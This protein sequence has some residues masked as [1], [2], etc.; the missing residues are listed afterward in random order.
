MTMQEP[1][2][3]V[4]GSEGLRQ[5]VLQA[6]GWVTGGFVFDKLIAA[7]QMMIVARLLTP[8]DFGLMA[9]S[10]VV[11]LAL[12]TLTEVGIETAL[13]SRQSVTKSDL[14]VAWSIS[15]GRASLLALAVWLFAG[16]IATFFRAPDLAL[17]LR[18]HALVLILE[19]AQSPA[20]ALLLR[21][22]ELGVRVRL[23]LLRRLTE[24]ATTIALAFW[25][26]SYWALLGGQLVGFAINGALSYRIAPFKPR[27]SLAPDSFKQ[28][29]RFGKHLNVTM[30]SI[31]GVTSLGEFVIG[32]LLGI[33]A[34]GVYQVALTIPILIGTRA[35]VVMTQVSFPTYAL[36][37]RDPSA[38]ARAFAFQMGVI[39]LL[40]IPVATALAIHA[41]DLV[42]LIFGPR[43][44]PAAE[45]FRVLCPFAVFA[46]LS[47]AM[48]SLHF[49]LNRPEFQSRIWKV[50]F[51]VYGAVVVP[52]TMKFQLI[53]A[54]AAFTLS[55]AVGFALHVSYSARLVGMEVR[56]TFL[57]LGRTVIPVFVIAVIIL[58]LQT[59]SL[60]P[61]VAWTL[62][63]FALVCAM[64][65]GLYLWRVE[66]PRLLALWREQ[67]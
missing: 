56:R 40:L 11:V 12:A 49:G 47:T 2:Q 42:I 53:G 51:L 7:V 25:L 19:G 33:E 64:V 31:F 29:M 21:N 1:I 10:A 22:L 54:A 32:R 4:R 66:C 39:G 3:G 61:P 57:A 14:E 48:A 63:L 46:C 13:V 28:F 20:M 38:I 41:K 9:A 27:L 65:Y 15:I 67:N 8:T 17:L 59:F 16:P 36:L 30:I 45:P 58:A 18:V 23:D 43:W 5:R 50:H 24:A 34:L 35:A 60:G 26:R 55:Y 62:I 44:L 52:L 37:Q 6:G